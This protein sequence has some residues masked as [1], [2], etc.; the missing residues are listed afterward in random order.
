MSSPNPMAGVRVL[1]LANNYAGPFA[2]SLL[3]DYGAEVVKVELP[4]TGDPARR[5]PPEKDGHSLGW[6]RINRGKKSIGLDLRDP[7][8]RETVVRLAAKADVIIVAFRPPT[9]AKWGLTYDDL[10]AANPGIVYVSVTGWG[11]T[12]PNSGRP[13]FG[14]TADAVSGFSHIVGFPDRPPVLAHFGLTDLIA[15]TSAALGTVMALFKRATT[16][17]GDLI[18]VALYEP[19]MH[20]LGDIVVD[21][22]TTGR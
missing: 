9:L 19:M 22:S 11:L 6:M 2:G 10:K 15:G 16:G 14:S 1:E 8:D 5:W 18:D 21:Y 12:G 7:R 3:C 4:G 13:G 17:E 20:L